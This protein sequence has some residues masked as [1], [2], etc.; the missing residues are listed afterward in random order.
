VFEFFYLVQAKSPDQGLLLGKYQFTLY[1]QA[2]KAIFGANSVPDLEL[3]NPT[4]G[5][6]STFWGPAYLDFGYLMIVYGFAFGYVTGCVRRLVQ[7]GDLFALPLY[8]LLIL[9][10]FLI[11]IVNGVLMASA[12]I[13]NDGFFGIW[14]LSRW[15]FERRLAVVGVT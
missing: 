6:F 12:V 13:L 10:I 7:R 3:L 2:Q 4:T 11:P 1:G 9:Q 14:L 8:V 15:H 5:L